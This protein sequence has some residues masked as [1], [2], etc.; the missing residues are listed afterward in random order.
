MRIYTRSGDDGSTALANGTRVSKATLRVDAYGQV[1]ELNSA[2]GVLVAVMAPQPAPAEL[3]RAQDALFHVG[4]LLAD[5]LGRHRPPAD[6]MHAA[7]LERWIDQMESELP[8]LRHFILPGGSRAAAFAHL[9]RAVCRR[10]ER[11][12]AALHEAGE[13]AAGEALPLL[14]RLSD[15]LFVCARWLNQ[16]AGAVDV[17]WRPRG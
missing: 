3:G 11:Q 15:A 6:L 8:P 13:N 17:V 9:A 2:I 4:A 10:A 1:D 7:W 16:R 5:P 14:N 12:V